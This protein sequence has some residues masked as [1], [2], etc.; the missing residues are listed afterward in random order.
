MPRTRRA[1]ITT[2]R[3]NASSAMTVAKAR[4]FFQ[5]IIDLIDTDDN[6]KLSIKNVISSKRTHNS[7][8]I[9]IV[10]FKDATTIFLDNRITTTIGLIPQTMTEINIVRKGIYWIN[11]KLFTGASYSFEK[12]NFKETLD[13]AIP[14]ENSTVQLDLLCQ[15][16]LSI[17]EQGGNIHSDS[18]N[19]G[20]HCLYIALD[21]YRVLLHFQGGR[22]GE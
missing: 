9:Y 14:Y 15:F 20:N 17:S 21:K 19:N 22:D 5:N 7:R 11:S 16:D 13:Y 6:N 2:K 10:E 8:E 3:H 4:N 12:S 18:H 1:P